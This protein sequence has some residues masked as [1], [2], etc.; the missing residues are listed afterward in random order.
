MHFQL[1][2]KVCKCVC[3]NQTEPSGF[4]S[5]SMKIFPFDTKGSSLK[6]ILHYLISY[7]II[8]NINEAKT[9]FVRFDCRIKLRIKT[10]S[11]LQN[12]RL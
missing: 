12:A 4:F 2:G 5:P 6:K 7:S 8:N 10:S 9:F 1:D 3:C 11:P